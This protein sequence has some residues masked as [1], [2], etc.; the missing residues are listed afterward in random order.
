[1]HDVNTTTEKHHHIW[2]ILLWVYN[3]QCLSS[4]VSKSLRSFINITLSETP[5]Y[6]SESF[7]FLLYPA[8]NSLIR[9]K[10]IKCIWRCTRQQT[11]AI[12]FSD[13]FSENKMLYKFLKQIEMTVH[14]SIYCNTAS[15]KSTH[16]TIVAPFTAPDVI[17]PIR[18]RKESIFHFAILHDQLC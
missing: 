6:K 5:Y 15:S 3:N 4:S 11:T 8:G 10:Y 1:M 17:S 14:D 16:V 18:A 13:S 12:A 7:V 2:K 9:D